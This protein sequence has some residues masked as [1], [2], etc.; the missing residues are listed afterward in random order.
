[1][2]ICRN[3]AAY[4]NE[5]EQ[6]EHP[7]E[8]QVHDTNQNPHKTQCSGGKRKLKKKRYRANWGETFP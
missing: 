1:M 4:F 2:Y 8:T 6:V 3:T 7:V 5:G